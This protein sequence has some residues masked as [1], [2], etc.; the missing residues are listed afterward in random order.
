MSGYPLLFAVLLAGPGLQNAEVMPKSGPVAMLDSDA[1][2]KLLI[3]VAKPAYPAIAKVNFIQGLVTLEISVDKLG[4]VVAAHVVKGQPFLAAAAIEA[5]RKWLYR[6]YIGSGGPSP[7]RTS[8]AVRFALRSHVFGKSFPSDPQSFLEKQIRP[9]EIVSCPYSDPS[10]AGVRLKVLVD[11]KG[12]VLDATS[13]GAGG[14]EVEFARE[15]LRYWRFR[16]ARWG[17]M[18]V[19]WYVIVKVPFEHVLA[20][21]A[22]YSA[23]H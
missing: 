2:A 20:D 17:A 10:A 7:F 4:K 21:E 3:H 11:S 6:P 15:D 19:P 23:R 5:V 18:A 13:L 8:V 1:A 9:P 12:K 22:A 16:P 14:T